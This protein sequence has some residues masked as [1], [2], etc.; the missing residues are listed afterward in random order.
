MWVSRFYTTMGA[1]NEKEKDW[2]TSNISVQL[3]DVCSSVVVNGTLRSAVVFLATLPWVTG[4]QYFANPGISVSLK[5]KNIFVVHE[6]LHRDTTMK[7][8][9]CFLCNFK[10]FYLILEIKVNFWYSVCLHKYKSIFVGLR[11]PRTSKEILTFAVIR[12]SF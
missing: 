12:C 8:C 11:A 4:L 1:E 7:I 3:L 5:D 2:N 6:S 9:F 10:V